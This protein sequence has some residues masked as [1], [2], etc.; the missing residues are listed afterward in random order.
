[1]AAFTARP[2][3]ASTGCVRSVV[4]MCGV[5]MRGACVR[6]HIGVHERMNTVWRCSTRGLLH[7]VLHTLQAAGTSTTHAPGGRNH[8]STP[9]L[10][11]SCLNRAW[12][13][14]ERLSHDSKYSNLSAS[15]PAARASS[16]ASFTKFF[17]VRPAHS[18]AMSVSTHAFFCDKQVA[19]V[20]VCVCVRVH[21]RVRVR[22]CECTCVYTRMCVVCSRCAHV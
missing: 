1:M 4:P 9:L 5:C 12:H 14:A 11:H 8:G 10:R 7:V 19:C 16:F 21:V 3:P 15:N 20:C 18:T 17:S 22:V 6:V 13:W 2:N